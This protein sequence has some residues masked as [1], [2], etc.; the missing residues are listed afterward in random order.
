MNPWVRSTHENVRKRSIKAD[1]ESQDLA[2]FLQLPTGN[3][4]EIRGTQ[5]ARQNSSRMLRTNLQGALTPRGRGTLH[6]ILPADCRHASLL[7]GSERLVPHQAISLLY[8]LLPS[9]EREPQHPTLEAHPTNPGWGALRHKGF[10]H[11]NLTA[12]RPFLLDANQRL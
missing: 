4:Q 7:L 8:S 3:C 1:S 6:C 9:W 2:A 11:W 10:P 12:K 5:N